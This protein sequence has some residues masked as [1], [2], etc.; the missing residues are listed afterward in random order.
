[1]QNDEVAPPGEDVVEAPLSPEEVVGAIAVSKIVELPRFGCCE[2]A[3]NHILI[4]EDFNGTEVARKIARIGMRGT[5]E[6]QSIAAESS[7]S[8]GGRHRT[9]SWPDTVQ[10]QRA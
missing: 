2:P 10:L 6:R 8:R 4:D 7:R 1:M 3:A 9:A 5:I